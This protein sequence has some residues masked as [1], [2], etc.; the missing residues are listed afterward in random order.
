MYENYRQSGSQQRAYFAGLSNGRDRQP[1]AAGAW[2]R[3][4]MRLS[5]FSVL[6]TMF[7]T[8]VWSAGMAQVVSLKGDK[9]SLRQVFKDINKQTGYHYLWS[10]Q[11]IQPS[12]RI[13]V[14]I[15]RKPLA[16]ALPLILNGLDLTYE[17]ENKTIVIKEKAVASPSNNPIKLAETPIYVQQIMRG[18]VVNA[19]GE[20]VSGVTIRIK[21]TNVVTTSNSNG[22]FSFDKQ[23][24]DKQVLVFT[25]VGYVP[26]EL[27]AKAQLGDIKLEELNNS[28]EGIELV[29]NTGYQK[30]SKERAAGSFAQ[31]NSEDMESR[32]QTNFL[33]RTEGLLPGMNLSLNKAAA[34]PMNK[35]NDV[36][37]VVRGT[38]TLNAQAAPL[39]V[40]DG[41]PYEGDLTAI[42]PNDVETMT[43][44]KD[45]SAA[46]IYGVRSSNGV[47]VITTK[48]GKEGPAKID[49]A[50]TLVL[51]GLPDR[52]YLNQMSSAE[53]VDFQKEM[54][55][56]RS[57]DY[58]SLDPKRA[59]SDVYRTL[60]EFKGGKI[61]AVELERQLD[62]FRNRNRFDHMD[63]FL[64]SHILDQQHNLS[65]SGASDRFKYYY[66]VNYNKPGD[67][68]KD[69]P[70]V[71]SIGFNIKNS[72][73]LTNWMNLNL[74][75]LGKNQKQN[76]A[77][78]FNFFDNYMGGKAS[79]YLL[80]NEDG[81]AAQWYNSKSQF[82][83]D[84]LNDLGLLDET[85]IPINEVNN[86]KVNYSNKY[87]NLNFGANFNLMPGLTFDVSY[88]TERTE[89]YNGTT[90][91]KDNQTVMAQI[92]DATQIDKE[93]VIKRNVPLGGQF[94]E[95]RLDINSYTL[96]GQLNFEKSFEGVHDV[97][98]I[99]GA[100]RR[101]INSRFTDIYK[102]GYDESSLVYKGINEEL[103]GVNIPNTQAI[104][105][106]YTLRKQETGFSDILDRFV[107]FY[108]NGS[109]T[110]QRNLTLSASIRMDQSNL[111]GTDIKTQYKPLW[112]VGAIYQ[113]PT[114]DQ[115]WL[116]R[117]AVR[118]TYGVNG[119]VPKENGP[120]LISRVS[121][122]LNYY[123][124]EMQASITTPPNPSLRW[125]RTDVLNFGID[126]ALLK[127]RL[128]GSI[129]L[130]NKKTTD[131]LGPTA[132]DPTL[133]WDIVDMNYGNMQ[134]RGIELGLN[135]KPIVRE[136]FRWN[137]TLNF[138]Y[139]KNEITHLYVQQNTPYYFYYAPQNRVG[140]PVGSMYSIDY[141][142]LNEKGEPLAQKKDGTVVKST[143]QLTMDDMIYNG[144]TVPPY[145]L[146]LRNGLQ[147]KG[148]NLDFMFVFNGGHLMRTVHPE[149]L[150]KF[151]E[152]NYNSNFDRLWL[153][154]W[155]KPGDEQ[156][157]DLA[158]A[159]LSGASGNVTDLYNAADKFVE[160]ADYIKLRD[161]SLSYTLPKA[162][163]GR[164][165]IRHVRLTGQ[166]LNAWRWT[167][168]SHNL[169]P[170]VWSGYSLVSTRG[171]LA[172]V[173][174]NFGLSI[175]I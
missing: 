52:G 63:E 156:N 5:V 80:R 98:V 45:A 75:V 89:G 101:Q 139:N 111:F 27:S 2:R 153:N 31:I 67:Y 16:E 7:L 69:R 94:S 17:I 159:F 72:V 155:K 129:D 136:H 151:A 60:Y 119:N 174:Y 12:A 91:T 1:A 138:S 171:V 29:V 74:N 85:Y 14:N 4:I 144:T 11:D 10:A 170:E 26:V 140:K 125:E 102:Y 137:S 33:D 104:F 41:M 147:Y 71:E 77:I 116:S 120:Y 109:Y 96:R 117:W 68:N 58:A 8:Q 35:K 81:S 160:K 115:D 173:T 121:P 143:Q 53:L 59:M 97:N 54:F 112:S 92:N 149:T 13:D 36:G 131:L 168:N 82:E 103:F 132:V 93:G 158:P 142:G 95:R 86:R 46:S 76:G 38:S 154:Y 126:F 25:C 18:R 141:V 6:M 9:V 164:T 20:P 40:V 134:N 110:Y 105:N 150:T 108:A 162:W 64:N 163:L 165:P 50:N 39:I 128:N 37:I 19:D 28:I 135:A 127:N 84:R 24:I 172:P 70:V 79:Y 175:G 130:Y 145:S 61:D 87:I 99:A 78:G 106:S 133:G 65:L 55:N 15:V 48:M 47:I 62:V 51:R 66:S 30:I 73:K 124:S 157:P 169:D 44:L 23:Y 32:L 100:E 49:Y 88:Q 83:I 22:E 123:T 166:I 152:L 161:V 34:N 42:N 146:A 148:F 107:S 114:F 21:G 57:G 167:A 3:C 43:V 118:L 90:F 113:M 122:S 56:Y